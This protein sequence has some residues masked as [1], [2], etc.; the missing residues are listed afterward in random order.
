[1]RGGSRGHRTLSWAPG[2]DQLQTQ[3]ETLGRDTSGTLCCTSHGQL[4]SGQGQCPAAPSASKGFS[5]LRSCLWHRRGLGNA[6]S[7]QPLAPNSFGAP[8]NGPHCPVLPKVSA[9][10]GTDSNCSMLSP[11]FPCKRD[12]GWGRQKE[13]EGVGE[14]KRRRRKH[15]PETWTANSKI[16]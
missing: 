9:T 2:M 1:M 5:S 12:W 10:V 3:E 14:R 16:F 15:T 11:L 6:L 4:P 13:E 8:W 7:C